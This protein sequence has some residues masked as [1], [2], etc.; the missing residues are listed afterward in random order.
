M[1]ITDAAEARDVVKQ[2]RENER[3]RLV[4]INDDVVKESDVPEVDRALQGWF[5]EKWPI[6]AEWES[7]S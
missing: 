2:L 7:I 4:C 1:S 6:P 5:H 3:L